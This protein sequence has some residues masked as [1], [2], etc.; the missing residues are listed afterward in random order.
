[1]YGFSVA[2]NYKTYGLIYYKDD[3]F[4]TMAGSCGS[5]LNGLSRVGFG[6]AMDRFSFKCNLSMLFF[7]QLIA[8]LILTLFVKIKLAFILS[9][10]LSYIS[11]G[12]YFVILPTF[13]SRFYGTKNGASIYG[14]ISFGNVLANFS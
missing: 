12:S 11:V 4:V 2:G 7:I 8:N 13:C 5:I 9:L 14:L 3:A 10:C 1:M 6:L